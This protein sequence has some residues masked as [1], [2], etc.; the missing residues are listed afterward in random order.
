MPFCIA[1][2]QASREEA[3]AA[4]KAGLQEREAAWRKEQSKQIRVRERRRAREDVAATLAEAKARKGAEDG[5]R[6]ELEV[7]ISTRI[8]G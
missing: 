6:A 3:L 1:T 7:R 5:L 2:S 8:L 4:E